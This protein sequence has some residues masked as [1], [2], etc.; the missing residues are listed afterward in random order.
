MLAAGAGL[1]PV[2]ADALPG[3]AVLLLLLLLILVLWRRRSGSGNRGG[4]RA[5]TA[6]LVN[7]VDERLLLHEP[8][9]AAE[10]AAMR[11]GIGCMQ[12]RVGAA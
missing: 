1:A 3:A 6:R 5:G 10:D 7:V 8:S 4:R 9:L 11:M 12:E 2:A